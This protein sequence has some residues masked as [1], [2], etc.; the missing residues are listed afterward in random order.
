M[1]TPK[2][3]IRT[4]QENR[5]G[6]QYPQPVERLNGKSYYEYSEDSFE[7]ENWGL[8]AKESY[9][10]N[11]ALDFSMFNSELWTNEKAKIKAFEKIYQFI[12]DGKSGSGSSITALFPFEIFL[13]NDGFEMV[14]FCELNAMNPGLKFIADSMV[15]DEIINPK[16]IFQN[17]CYLKDD[18]FI[19]LAFGIT[20]E[21]KK[22]NFYFK[23]SK[24]NHYFQVDNNIENYKKAIS[25]ALKPL[26]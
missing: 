19:Y 20:V 11:S 9:N 24:S 5:A 17:R 12:K 4:F 6:F 2:H 21:G 15:G 18:N 26:Y 7:R 22:T 8:I 10:Y 1:N 3:Y 16:G 25:G 13:M 14:S 23:T